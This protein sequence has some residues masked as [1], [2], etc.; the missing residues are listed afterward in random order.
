LGLLPGALSPTLAEGVTR[1]ASWMPFA[2]AAEQVAFFWRV[3][4]S[5]ATGRRHAEAAGATY[6]AV[7][8]AAV[9]RLE[10]DAPPA[11]PGPPVQLLSAD[12]AM[13]P[14]VGG[15]WAEVKTL[16]VGTVGAPAWDARAGEWVAPTTDLSYFSRQADAA[17]FTRLALGETHRRGTEA[18]GVVCAV[19]DGAEWVQGVVDHHRKDAVRVLDFPHAVERLATAAQATYG[20][21]TA[22]ADAWLAARAHDL[23]HGDPATVLAALRTLPTATAADPPAAAGARDATL[24]YLAARWPAIQ[25]AAFRAAGYPIG[26]GAVESA[27]KLVVE[28][29]LKGAGMHWARPNVTPMVALRTVA[30]AD[31]WPE[32]W[33][34]IVARRRTQTATR[35]QQRSR[36]R[37]PAAAPAPP[38]VPA[39]PTPRRH[40][41]A[42]PHPPPQRSGRPHPWRRPFSTAERL[43]QATAARL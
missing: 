41:T 1:L 10:R 32:A 5:A 31:R 34:Q 24:G 4:V 39:A 6:V 43:R 21:G 9:E 13:V 40:S 27:N 29:R 26:S 28:A 18:A 35:R 22:A 38:A 15:A 12:G 23:K 36:A 3:G 2:R 37:P 20:A 19:A 30:C 17:T 16:A 7:Q 33:P 8:T 14:L 11:P 25:Y 42:I